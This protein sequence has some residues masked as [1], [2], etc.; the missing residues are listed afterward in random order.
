MW[1]GVFD[2]RPTSSTMSD[3]A[4]V[5]PLAAAA[6]ISPVVFLVQFTTLT[7]PGRQSLTRNSGICSAVTCSPDA[8]SKERVWSKNAPQ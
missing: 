5:I 6:A 1:D 8:Q 3:L 2:R 4:Q 7:G